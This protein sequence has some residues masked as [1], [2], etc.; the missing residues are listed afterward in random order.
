MWVTYKLDEESLAIKRIVGPFE[1]HEA[2]RKYAIEHGFDGSILL[3]DPNE[4][5]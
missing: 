2:A 5:D 1:L 4:K 3:I